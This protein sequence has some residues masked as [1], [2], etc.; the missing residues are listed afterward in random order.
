MQQYRGVPVF[1]N[2]LRANVDRSGQLI[3]VLGSP[4]T[5]TV[6]SSI[7]PRLSAVAA[8]GRARQDGGATSL[9][10]SVTKTTPGPQRWTRFFDGSQADLVVFHIASGNELA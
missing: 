4:L 6:V 10:P 9:A 3:N 1:E 5:S 2:E 8:L 7:T